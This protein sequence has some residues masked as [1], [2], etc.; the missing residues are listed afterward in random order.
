MF[1]VT[2]IATWPRRVK[3]AQIVGPICCMA[4][5]RTL[6]KFITMPPGK[7]AP[8]QQSSLTDLWGGRQKKQSTPITPTNTGD[9]ITDAGPAES[10][11]RST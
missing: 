11:K 6:A 10:S 7:K 4:R 8:P 3:V 5:Q 1:T 2:A 9:A